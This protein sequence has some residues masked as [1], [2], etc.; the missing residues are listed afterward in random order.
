MTR[1]PANPKQ[2][3]PTGARAL[4]RRLRQVEKLIEPAAL[5]ASEDIEHVHKLRVATRRAQAALTIFQNELPPKLRKLANRRLRDIRRAASDARDADV[6]TVAF[7]SRP[8]PATTDERAA[9]E[10]VL[11][12]LAQDRADAQQK[13]LEAHRT[14][15]AAELKDARKQIEAATLDQSAAAHTAPL[16]VGSALA[17]VEDAAAAELSDIELIHDL[18][19]KA[20]QLRYTLELLHPEL[21]P[22]KTDAALADLRAMQDGLG[23]LNDESSIADRL[24]RYLEE[25]TENKATRRG[26]T[27]MLARSEAHLAQLCQSC[28]ETWTGPQAKELVADT[29]RL[30]RGPEPVT[31]MPKTPADSLAVKPTADPNRLAAI[32][33]GTNSIRLIIAELD[34]NG[35]Y[36]ILDDE[37][38]ITRL[39]TGLATTG[40]MSADAIERS[41]DAIKRMRDIADGFGASAIRAVGTAVARD[42]TNADELSDAMLRATGIE[43]EIISPQREAQ[44]AFR[45]VDAAFDIDDQSV[46]IVDIGGGST[47]V[48]MSSRGLIEAVYPIPMGA[49]RLTELF[50]GPEECCGP[51]FKEMRR[52]IRDEI[53]RIV[54]KPP[55][56]P[57]LMIGTGGTLTTLAAISAQQHQLAH[58][59]TRSAPAAR[60]HEMQRSD[61]RHLLDR[62]RKIPLEERA[63][64][65]GLPAD[66]AD[67]IV[68]GITIA[69]SLMK[70][71]GVN[72]A[73]VHDRGI[74]DG[75]LLEMAQEAQGKAAAPAPVDAMKSV[76]RFAEACRYDH[77]HCQHVATLALQ[78]FDQLRAQSESLTQRPAWA[79]SL[80]DEARTILEAASILQ[81]VG[82]HI[83][84]TRHHKHS[85][86][87]ILHADL[88]GLTTRQTRMI[89]NV[90]R[91]HRRAHP[92]IKHESFARLDAEDRSTV[93]ALAGILRLTGGLDRAHVQ[94]ITAVRATLN[95][96]NIQITASATQ[97]PHVELWGAARK[98]ELFKQ[99]FAL[100][101]E[102]DWAPPTPGASHKKAPNR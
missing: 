57:Q 70:R 94:R 80:T 20:K 24:R 59:P 68:A 77:T 34:G 99:H 40:L 69:E 50:G 71:L 54:K 22:E 17:A 18:R 36:R 30:I 81:D 15:T 44:L 19:K 28:A 85:H 21:P 58:D 98:S 48:V 84:Y 62:L 97:D 64:I 47:E 89:A 3:E 11:N 79:D 5:R 43:L 6:H 93:R 41:V 35:S 86:H 9:L 66:R 52:Y 88:P 45:S 39:G 87:L 53:K 55:F 65:P 75:L 26:L 33:L 100:D 73:R 42:A 7:T 4:H 51:R 49:V 14:N 101:V 13:L 32:D 8:K 25:P 67:I 12:R 56:I 92:N 29:R 61:F 90:A 31:P 72:E 83:N 16:A 23:E 63:Q 91:Y 95:D 38:E 82:Y 10:H 60:D 1:A 46:A 37:K 96:H 76:H 78:L 102:F 74:R 2:T 27:A